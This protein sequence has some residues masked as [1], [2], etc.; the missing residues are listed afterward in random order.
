MDIN[1]INNN[2]VSVNNED[3]EL[4][5]TILDHE[6]YTEKNELNN[7]KEEEIERKNNWLLIV[8]IILV[9]VLVLILISLP[10][11]SDYIAK[12]SNNPLRLVVRIILFLFLS[13]LFTLVIFYLN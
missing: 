3:I 7:T 6:I 11:T 9:C 4:L 2:D 8:N 13:F 5:K 10:P 1:S 12:I